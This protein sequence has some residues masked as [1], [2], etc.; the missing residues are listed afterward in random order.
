[1]VPDDPN[2]DADEV[3]KIP[4][5]APLSPEQNLSLPKKHRFYPE[6]IF[7]PK[8]RAKLGRAAR[9]LAIA[10][11]LVVVAGIGLGAYAVT[12]HQTTAT[13]SKGFKYVLPAFK[14][15]STVPADGET[16]V[17]VASSITLNFTQP[18]DA[19]KLSNNLFFTPTL[20]GVFKQGDSPKQAIF[21]P[22]QPLAKG[23]KVSLM[24]NAT[25]QSQ[26]GAKLGRAY[27]G[28]FTTS[29]P[30]TDIEFQDQNGLIDQVT[31]VPSGQKETYTTYV[32]DG[33][34]PGASISLYK[35]TTT[36]MLRTLIYQTSEQLGPSFTDFAT[37]TAGLELVATQSKVT[38]QGTY[39]VQQP[40]GLYAAV[41]TNA[42]G[43]Q[44]GMVWIN[45][46]SLGVV[47]RQDDQKT[48]LD[49]QDLSTGQDK[50]IS[51]SLYN[52]QGSV[53]ALS[54]QTINGLT[55]IQTP[56]KPSPDIGVAVAG[57]E[58]AIVPFTVLNSGGDIRVDQDLSTAQTV[59][60]T[61]DLPTYA[62]NAT[63]HF[64]GF[65]RNDND[66]VYTKPNGGTVSLYVAHYRGETPLYSFTAP[67]SGSG[68]INASIPASAAWLTSGD[69]YD[70]FQIFA[71]SVSGNSANDSSVASFNVTGGQ[72]AADKV[73]VSFSQGSYVPSDSIT[74][75]ISATNAS[76]QPLANQ[77]VQVH[78]FS[79]SY[80][81]DD[82]ASNLAT[83]GSGGTELPGSPFT[84]KLNGQGQATYTVNPASVP[85]GDTSQQVT[86]NVNVVGQSGVGGAGGDSA[87]IHQGN[88]VIGFGVD[89]NQIPAGTDVVS[90]VY[91]SH[92]DGTAYQNQSVAYKLLNAGT[93]AVVAT[94]R[95]T[96]DSNGIAAI[97]LPGIKV[98][99]DGATFVVSTTDSN[100]NVV[101]A[102]TYY[103]NTN[104]SS[105]V[106][107]TS[108][109][110]LMDLNATG[111]SSDVSV[112]QTVS[113]TI[114]SPAQLHTLVSYDRGRVYNPSMLTLQ[115]GNNDFSFVVT[116]NLGP[117]FTLTFN[118]FLNGVYHS[119]GIYFKVSDPTKAAG[120]SITPGSTA[121]KANQPATFTL[122]ST[123]SNGAGLASTM[124]VSV[125][126]A[127]TY[128]L[129]NQVTPPLFSQ[130]YGPRQ[131]MTSSTSSLSPIGSG[132][133]RCGG[134]GDD[135]LA[136]A[137]P[138][139]T[140]LYWQSDLRTA[141]DGTA[142]VSF[143]PPA[144]T[145]IM[146]VYD[147]SDST[148]VGSHSIT[149]TAQ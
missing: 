45:F 103:S 12:R 65:V 71:S 24:L 85:D 99:A 141:G 68:T 21:V 82:P 15:A 46:T 79:Q 105:E 92:L 91:V 1:M 47:A 119:E 29:I 35:G 100:G 132:G 137:N 128:S 42:A 40:D 38:D 20:K 2:N 89:R 122:K 28:S 52:L 96:T 62:S 53:R 135:L 83:F 124:L 115:K 26:S 23:S 143:T 66:A 97:T 116:P 134:G 142:S 129:S 19:Q 34:G 61:T 130:V 78:V 51:L 95:A 4:E 64:A 94:G 55:T 54:T 84:V 144:G 30:S 106:F 140:S 131:I 111:S 123:S 74:A 49:A 117:S 76:N 98:P 90:H 148:V 113:L 133:G 127:Y 107:D 43:K 126:S 67:I 145:W 138:I 72:N 39:T 16:D 59:F 9:P 147:M 56:F 112:G 36:A 33:V 41:A 31:S 57:S 14:L 32:G 88:A 93:S 48:V 125:V 77:T 108:G 37:S 17:N 75:S 70:H 10:L 80:Y 11:I 25:F 149:F 114:S 136:F 86:L 139:G 63:I 121:V 44:V 6:I 60:G 5:E 8:L 109:A 104:S 110:G 58:L 146:T 18:V 81:E 73:S 13:A 3:E 7:I 120:V 27:G 102:K 101:S 87:I 69:P 22:S 118:Y 50:A